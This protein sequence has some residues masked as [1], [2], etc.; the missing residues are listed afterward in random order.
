MAS[1]NRTCTGTHP[2]PL[3]RHD[4]VN[5]YPIG[6]PSIVDQ[7]LGRNPGDQDHY[8]VPGQYGTP[9]V[10]VGLALLLGSMPFLAGRT[11]RGPRWAAVA[12]LG[13]AWL[14]ISF[15]ALVL[16]L[17]VWWERWH[18][19][20]V[21]AACLLAGAG[22]VSVGRIPASL[23]VAAQALSALA[24]GPSFLNRGFWDVVGSPVGIGLHAVAGVAIIVSVANSSGVPQW[25]RARQLADAVG[26]TLIG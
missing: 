6:F 1:L 25:V 18:L 9:A 16:S 8:L 24:I 19:G 17:P 22:L 21:P 20:I 5:G 2:A 26:R 10:G 7:T 11:R 13:A 14:A 15:T 23:A 3:P 4:P 12:S